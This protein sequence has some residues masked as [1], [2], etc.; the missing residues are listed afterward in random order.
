M[1]ED[2][3][4]EL[5]YSDFSKATARVLDK[6]YNEKDRVLPLSKFVNCIETLGDGFHSEDL[7][8]HMRKLDPDEIGSVYRFPFLKWYVDEEVSLDSSEE[9][10]C[11]VGWGCKVVLVDLQ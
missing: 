1:I 3:I 6:V 7:A 11:L 8:G 10:E 2:D 9:A 4:Y 5:P